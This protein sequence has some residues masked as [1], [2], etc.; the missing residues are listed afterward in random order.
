MVC[1]V[2]KLDAVLRAAPAA[3]QGLEFGKHLMPL[4][5]NSS[6]K[7]TS[8]S[9]LGTTSSSATWLIQLWHSR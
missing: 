4:S 3:G 9:R 7:L 8:M 1:F 5:N 2:A 6:V